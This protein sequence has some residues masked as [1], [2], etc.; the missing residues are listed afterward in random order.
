MCGIR[1]VPPALDVLPRWLA[2]R[3]PFP[4]PNAAWF[5]T[6]IVKLHG[7]TW[8]DGAH[9]ANMPPPADFMLAMAHF[10]FNG[11]TWRK[12][13]SALI[14]R[15][16][17]R[18]GKKYEHYEDMLDVM[19]RRGLG[20]LGAPSQRYSTPAQLLAAGLMKLPAETS[21]EGRPR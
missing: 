7:E 14:L 13:Q 12:I 2:A 20:F 16:H 10:K 15:S 18:G 9:E 1:Q 19:Q 17:A 11:D 6:P 4:V 21:G 5:K 8:L 3:L